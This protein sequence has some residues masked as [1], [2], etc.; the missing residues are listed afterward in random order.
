MTTEAAALLYEAQHLHQWEGRPLAV[1]NP[2]NRP[3]EELP[4]IYGFNNGGGGNWWHA[5]LIA[6]DGLGLGGHLC[7]SEVYMPHDLGCLE[8][9][10]PDRH[11]A[12]QKH[13]PDGYRMAFVPLDQVCG[14][15]KL[16][17]AFALNAKL[18]KAAK[19]SA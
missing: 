4:T 18:A 5:Q 3:V 15:E 2:N 8:G 19:V 10:R 1:F 12:F 16:N 6:E 7:S 9:S 17:A 13:Y 14:H 11:E